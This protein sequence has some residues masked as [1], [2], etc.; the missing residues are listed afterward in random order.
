DGSEV[1]C[2][3]SHHTLRFAAL[4]SALAPFQVRSFRFQWP[5]DLA[6]SIGYETESLILGWYIL[7]T[8]GSVEYLV[9][10]GSLTWIGAI[11]SPFFG[12]AADHYGVRNFLYATRGV[13]AALA[14]V[15]MALT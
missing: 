4:A 10:F 13:Y 1:E 5:A 3:R 6:A 12:T 2:Q 9:A 15:R 14:A 11:F 8:T 7:S